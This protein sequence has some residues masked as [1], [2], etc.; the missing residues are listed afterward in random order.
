[1]RI[2]VQEGGLTKFNRIREIRLRFPPGKQNRQSFLYDLFWFPISF[3]FS[4]VLKFLVS[5]LELSRTSCHHIS[6]F[7]VLLP[8]CIISD[9]QQAIKKQSNPYVTRLKNPKDYTNNFIINTF[10][11]NR[12]MT[13]CLHMYLVHIVVYTFIT[14]NKPYGRCYHICMFLESHLLLHER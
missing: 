7:L 13:R 12:E 5:L 2:T 4:T 10:F 14:R 9:Q 8:R 11:F 1:M 3:C 6:A